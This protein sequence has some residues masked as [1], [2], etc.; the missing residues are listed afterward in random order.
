MAKVVGREGHKPRKR[1]ARIFFR[2]CLLTLVLM[3][4]FTKLEIEWVGIWHSSIN[5]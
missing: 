3:D 5:F 2:N 1:K 4:H